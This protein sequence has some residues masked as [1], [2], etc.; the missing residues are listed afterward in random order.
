MPGGL[1]G[2]LLRL[3]FQ[4]PVQLLQVDDSLRKKGIVNEA[5]LHSLVTTLCV[6]QDY[7]NLR[8]IPATSAELPS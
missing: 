8:G 5:M 2:F 1:Q 3:S 7:G 6:A 4:L